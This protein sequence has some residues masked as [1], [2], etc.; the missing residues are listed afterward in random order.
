MNQLYQTMVKAKYT[1]DSLSLPT[2]SIKAMMLVWKLRGKNIR[3]VLCCV[4]RLCTM[5]CTHTWAVPPGDCLV[6]GFFFVCRRWSLYFMHVSFSLFCVRLCFLSTSQGTDWKKC[7]RN[8]LFVSMGIYMYGTV[9]SVTLEFKDF[10]GPF[11]DNSERH[12][13]TLLVKST[14]SQCF[15]QEYLQNSQLPFEVPK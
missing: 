10:Q 2:D 9:S 3:A 1:Q 12:S 5:T 14:C 13:I 7:L 11:Y 15:S 8:D 4:W 6:L